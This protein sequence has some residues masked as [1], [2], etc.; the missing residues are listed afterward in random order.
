MNNLY[1]AVTLAA[2]AVTATLGSQSAAAVTGYIP[3]LGEFMAATQ[4]RH[5]KLWFAGQAGNWALAGYEI[6]EIKEGF[7]DITNYHPTHE[8]SPVPTQEILPKLTAAPLAKL[9]AA[10]N[11]H[12][13][14]K[15]D[16]AFD[17]LTA[18]CNAC[19][20]AENYGFNVIIRPSSNPYTNQNFRSSHPIHSTSNQKSK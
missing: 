2:A 5:S 7:E 17:A 12:S 15:F 6:D 11:S 3:G 8:G 16:E 4:M 18:S 14:E 19:H 9:Q 20:Q 13:L 1:L 10:V